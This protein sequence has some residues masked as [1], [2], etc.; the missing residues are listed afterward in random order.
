MPCIY[1][2]GLRDIF[3]QCNSKFKKEKLLENKKRRPL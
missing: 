3:Q 1:K 2:E